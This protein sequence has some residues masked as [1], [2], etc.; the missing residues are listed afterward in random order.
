MP[1]S[2][3]SIDIN[4]SI[5]LGVN[6]H[7]K[8][9]AVTAANGDGRTILKNNKIINASVSKAVNQLIT[10]A[11]DHNFIKKD[12]STVISIT[13][14]SDNDKIA[15]KLV[16]VSKKATSSAVDAGK[17]TAIYY[18]DTS[19]LSIRKEAEAYGV[20]LGK[21]KLI[22]TLQNI[23]SSI[24]V[25]ELKDASMTDLMYQLKDKLEIS[26]KEQSKSINTY[27]LTK[28]SDFVNSQFKK[29]T[30]NRG[31]DNKNS[32]N[33]EQ[34]SKS[35]NKDNIC[36]EYNQ[37]SAGVGQTF[38]VKLISKTEDGKF[39]EFKGK[40]DYSFD[41]AYISYDNTQFKALKEGKTEIKATYKENEA[42]LFVTIGQQ[43]DNKEKNMFFFNM[44]DFSVG[45]N[46]SC[47]F[48]VITV[49]NGEKKDITKDCKFYYNEA[50]LNV[51]RNQQNIKGLSLGKTVLKAE[52]KGMSANATVNVINKPQSDGENQK[53]KD[54]SAEIAR[55]QEIEKMALDYGVDIKG[56]PMNQAEQKVRE[57][58]AA[59]QGVDITGLSPA[60]ADKLLA[61][62]KNNQMTA[63]GILFQNTAGLL[64]LNTNAITPVM[65]KEVGGKLGINF[66]G[67]SLEQEVQAIQE[68]LAKL[69]LQLP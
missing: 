20:T 38:N 60:D 63:E 2:F 17:I 47:Y 53:D 40:C 44:N 22:K 36:F 26:S 57:A 28:I 43:K 66:E 11:V 68:A 42:I 8:V 61:E 32:Q 14:I 62:T 25:D 39:V 37:L 13:G 27:D 10:A 69:N 5:E 58:I 65:K 1:V 7:G 45:L 55:A 50:A 29:N 51:D 9:I 56:L 16:E 15:K 21:F 64:G 33:T 59:W 35:F 52:Y 49:Y 24:S 31:N 4:P 6:E 67:M 30:D 41:P 54:I 3:V 46:G 18:E 48:Q 19:D 12:G 23:D 34:Q